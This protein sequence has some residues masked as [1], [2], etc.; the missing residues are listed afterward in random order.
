MATVKV[1]RWVAPD[2]GGL[3]EL[4]HRRGLKSSAANRI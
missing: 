2:H 4:Y 3:R 1:K